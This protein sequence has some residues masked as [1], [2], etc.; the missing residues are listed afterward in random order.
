MVREN[1][2]A[3]VVTKYMTPQNT[4][5]R[6]KMETSF[7]IHKIFSPHWKSVPYNKSFVHINLNERKK[8]CN[9]TQSYFVS[10]LHLCIKFVTKEC[11]V[12]NPRPLLSI[13]AVLFICMYTL[14]VQIHYPDLLS[15]GYEF[16]FRIELLLYYSKQLNYK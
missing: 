12:F 3:K 16:S 6:L 5:S 14:Y 9:I 13:L 8:T 15:L 1:S 11:I 4:H 10:V 7:L 2:G